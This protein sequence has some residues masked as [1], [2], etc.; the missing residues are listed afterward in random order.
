VRKGAKKRMADCG[1]PQDEQLFHDSYGELDA[2]AKGDGFETRPYEFGTK[3]LPN[4]E[5]PDETLL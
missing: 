2:V 5:G 1:T 4:H 3:A